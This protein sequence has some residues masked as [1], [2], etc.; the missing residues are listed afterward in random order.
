MSKICANMYLVVE[1]GNNISKK[2]VEEKIQHLLRLMDKMQMQ[3]NLQFAIAEVSMSDVKSF[4][5]YFSRNNESLDISEI[6]LTSIARGLVNK[7]QVDVELVSCEK[8]QTLK[9]EPKAPENRC[10][11]PV[12]KL[13]VEAMNDLAG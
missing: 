11:E 12:E 3:H 13:L 5:V 9:F 4:N 8:K 6:N 1:A 10:Y 7:F 2:S